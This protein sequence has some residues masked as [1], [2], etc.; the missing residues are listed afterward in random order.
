KYSS[1][2]EARALAN[3]VYLMYGEL[4]DVFDQFLGT[5]QISVPSARGGTTSIHKNYI[6]AGYLSGRTIHAHQGYTQLQKVI[7]KVRHLLK[8]PSN[9]SGSR[10]TATQKDVFEI[11]SRFR[12]CCQYLT[13]PFDNERSVQDIAWIM[14]RSHF[15]DLKREDTIPSF[16]VKN[17]RPDFSI[18]EVGLYVEIK[19]IGP[20]TRPADI[21]EE[22]LADIPGYLAA[23][24]SFDA[25]LIC[26]YDSSHKL[27]N[28]KA[29][30]EDIR[31]V[32]GI[33][34]VIVIPGIG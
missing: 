32:D 13:I 4:E 16:G 30:I 25:I 11:L 17:Y 14:L 7:G 8:Q 9:Q 33:L 15:D 10:S 12:E 21:Q 5:S 28:P 1:T 22:I 19:F 23:D 20:R 29:F 18:P 6:E 26:V 31:S 3:E 34:D 2:D 27:R 24:S